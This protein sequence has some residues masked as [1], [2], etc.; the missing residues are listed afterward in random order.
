MSEIK[1]K[2][3]SNR[4]LDLPVMLAIVAALVAIVF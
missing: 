4:W 1:I 2:G 3:T